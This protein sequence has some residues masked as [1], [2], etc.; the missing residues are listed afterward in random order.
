M[1]ASR[2]SDLLADPLVGVA[3]AIAASTPTSVDAGRGGAPDARVGVLA[4]ERH[5]GR[6]ASSSVRRR[7]L[8]HGGE[9]EPQDLADLCLGW[10]LKRSRKDIGSLTQSGNLEMWNLEI[11]IS[12]FPHFQISKLQ[13]LVTVIQ[14]SANRRS[15]LAS[16]R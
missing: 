9:R 1:P 12:R 2:P 4:G 10:I 7:Q 15:A 13:T 8:L 14:P 5:E 16:S 3:A 6:R 11:S